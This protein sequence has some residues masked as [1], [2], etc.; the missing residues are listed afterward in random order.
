MLISSEAAFLNV[1]ASFFLRIFSSIF[2]EAD[3]EVQVVLAFVVPVIKFVIKYV[4]KRLVS[5][6]NPD[7]AHGAAFMTE[8]LT[9]SIS[10]I[11]FTSIKNRKF[12]NFIPSNEQR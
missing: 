8:C 6:S 11:L 3:S 7:F 1:G 5:R 12:M 2:A 10:T 9:G 4:I